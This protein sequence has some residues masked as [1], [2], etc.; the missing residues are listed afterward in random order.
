MEIIH[1]Q[2]HYEVYLE[3]KFILSAD[4]KAE[5]IRETEIYMNEGR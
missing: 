3:G 2:S 5:A 4:T 1:V